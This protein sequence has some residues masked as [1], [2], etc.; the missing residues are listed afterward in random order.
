MSNEEL[1]NSDIL[2][3]RIMD[4][5][6]ENLTERE[7]ESEIKRI[8]YE[9]TGN[10]L[11]ANVTIYRSDDILDERRENEVDSGF[12]GTILHFQSEEQR[13]NQAITIT[14]GSE[15]GEKDTW[16]PIDWTYNLMGIFVGG[17]DNQ[18]QD[19]KIFY[20]EVHSV[21]QNRK[22]ELPSL[23]KYGYG[24]SLGGNNI[25]ILQLM[26]R[27]EENLRFKNVYAI[28]DA[29]PT[30]YQL[31]AI[32]LDFRESVNN[33]FKI[34]NDEDIYKI[35]SNELKAF[36]EEYYKNKIDETT[37][38][39]LTAEEDMLYGVSGVRGFLEIG[40][41]NGFL[42]TDPRYAGIREL[43]D[44]IPDKDL[45][46]IQMFLS[47]YS[48]TYDT[49]GIDG[50]LRGLTGFNPA[51]VDS[52]L[53]SSD[54]F[55]ETVEKIQKSVDGLEKPFTDVT[56]ADSFLS[57][58]KESLT[59]PFDLF[60]ANLNL[61]KEVVTGF[62][63]TVGNLTGLIV[64]A[65]PM[66]IDMAEKMP[67]LISNVKVLYQNLD[68]ILQAFVDV[69]FISQVEKDQIIS[70]VK[71]IETSLEVIQTTIDESLDPSLLLALNSKDPMNQMKEIA[72]IV[73]ALQT[74]KAEVN[75]IKEALE[76][77]KNV[78][79]SFM[80]QFSG[81]A[82]AHKLDAV[83]NGLVHDKNISYVNNDMYMSPSGKGEIKVNIS[84]SVRIYQKGLAISQEKESNVNRLKTLFNSEYMDDYD[85]RM[86]SIM[87]KVHM[88]ESNPKQYSYL[89]TQTMPY[90]LGG[91][92]ELKKINVN[93]QLPPLPATFNQSFSQMI[94]TIEA[95]IEKEKLLVKK[96]RDSIE[97]LFSEEERISKMF[98]YRYGG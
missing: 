25:T 10:K 26:S 34:M 97:D 70:Y 79:T 13:I 88:M 56:N 9:E 51:V 36:A 29:T 48:T 60:G 91:Y 22:G 57:F 5:E 50:F 66:I 15:L 19:A 18:Y 95:D 76:G 11:T 59:L 41:R 17:T 55:S 6:Y 32:D 49:E 35:P 54:E 40:D 21:V 81:S 39:H 94:E 46:T 12:D 52:I 93:E 86:Q 28:N 45:R 71:E 72:K 38:N 31:A 87:T 24:H 44:K 85:E 16:K 61:Q 65:V 68:P 89:L 7:I 64:E 8:Y 96:I 92:Y 75:D 73:D 90:P 74:I 58:A 43:I 84:S 2:R 53:T 78:D 20:D 80:E 69:G 1:L 82:H 30:A 42:D 63:Q 67:K 27:N 14:R 98:D 33:K 77:L 23:E 62:F 3:A 4:L 83:V 37:I 47:N